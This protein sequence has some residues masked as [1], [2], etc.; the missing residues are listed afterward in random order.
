MPILYRLLRLS[1]TSWGSTGIFATFL[2]ISET[3]LLKMSLMSLSLDKNSSKLLISYFFFNSSK[4]VL[5]AK[6]AGSEWKSA[7]F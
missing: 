6:T 3:S 2:L 4:S 5:I 7:S 1:S